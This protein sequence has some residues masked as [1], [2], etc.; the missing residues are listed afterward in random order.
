MN[1]I[2]ALLTISLTISAV[3]EWIERCDTP[4]QGGYGEAVV[5]TGNAVYIA[6]CLYSSSFPQFW[7]Y[8][9]EENIWYDLNTDALPTGA[10]RNGA[11]LAY[12]YNGKIYALLGGK[13]SDENR[14]LFYYF[15]LST[16]SWHCLPNTPHAQG[17]GDAL[18]YCMYDDKLYAFLG[19]RL[20]GTVFA[21]YNISNS[22]WQV[23]PS[24]WNLTDDGCSLVW[25]GGKYLYALQ[26]EIYEE[27]PNC[28]FARY[29]ILNMTWEELSPIPE[30]NGVGDGASLLWIGYW[31]KCYKNRIFALGGGGADESPGY[32]FYCY[33]INNDTWTKLNNIPYP[34]GYYNGNRLAY[35]NNS[36]Y[37]WQGTPSTW[38]GGGKKFCQYLLKPSVV[39]VDDDFNSSTPGWQYNAFDSIQDGIDACKEGGMVYVYEG[40][41][42]ENVVINKSINL[43]GYDAIIH[44]NNTAISV[45][46]SWVNISNFTII[47]NYGIYLSSNNSRICRCN[48]LNNT[49]GIY[50]FNSNNN[51]I[52]LNN[53]IGSNAVS[54]NS[55]NM[56][57]SANLINY[58]YDNT[59]FSNYLGNYWYDYN[60][61]DAN[62]DGI[63]DDAYHINENEYDGYPLL[64]Q[65]ENYLRKSFT[66]NLLEGWNFIT[67]PLKNEYKASSLFSSIPN[68]LAILSWNA[69]QQNFMIYVPHSPYNFS[70]EDGKGYFIAVGNAT[71]FN[72]TG[73]AIGGVS[74]KLYEGW[75][76]LGWFKENEINAS[77]L[78][79]SIEECIALLKWNASQQNFMIYVPH[80]PYDFIIKR[81]D[82]FLV[83]TEKQSIWHG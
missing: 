73:I 27:E 54:I 68:C 41:Y 35:A 50:S 30:E 6:R 1:K 33:F 17:A 7:M 12:D 16:H 76:A 65:W 74:L 69:S 13:Y 83:A 78:F 53:F 77:S 36:I 24:I 48:F 55:S 28:N 20:H 82:G 57:N 19:S 80:A 81:G 79:Q 31:N 64:M 22:S 14:T 42:Y 58:T 11:S 66:F 21:C 62:K 51:K 2:I 3:H 38:E 26:G 45:K 60:G 70:I 34:V 46:A 44:G 40:T 75:N 29:D 56:W 61:I 49:I 43:I 4:E 67:L 32:G 5:G 52:Y 37:Y 9:S 63:G 71:S 47:G 72:I 8:N 10:F 18:A 25:A 15:D 39:Y 23:L 59:S